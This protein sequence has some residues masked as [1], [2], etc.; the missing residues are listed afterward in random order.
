MK[1]V[2]RGE[3]GGTAPVPAHR[4]TVCRLLP[5]RRAVWRR[6]EAIP[7]DRR[8]LYSAA[9]EERIGCCRKTGKGLSYSGQCRALAE[10]RS[11][12]PGMAACPVA[13]QRG[14]LKR[15]DEAF[16][17][18]FRR[19]R[20]GGAPGFPRFR[21]R[22]S[23][24]SFRAV[25]GVRIRGGRIHLPGLGG[26]AV[27]RKGGNPYPDGRPV[28]AVLKRTGGKRFVTVC[29]TV[30]AEGP[31]DNGHAVGIDRNAGQV[32]GSDG[33]IHA[34]PDMARLE[35]KCRRLARRVSR[36]RKGSRRRERAK[37]QLAKARRKAANQRHNWHHQVSR[38][39]AERAGTVVLERLDVRG[40]TRSAKGTA[41]SPGRNL[42]QKASLNRAITG[43]GWTAFAAM[44]ECKAAN[45]IHVPAA[46]TS[47][48]CHECGA[49]DAASRGSQAESVCVACGHA[50]SA[51]VNAAKNIPAS[52]TGASARRGAFA[53]ATPATREISAE[54]G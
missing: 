45:V 47:Q 33:V 27:R 7:E 19:V 3:G 24:D 16:R 20:A 2:R 14:A 35:A 50:A 39:I 29:Y 9:L 46:Y 32:A 1:T 25:S 28:S 18:F 6:P 48:T 22:R 42:K 34:M 37:R 13:I 53:S 31:A 54:A 43:T 10:C 26:M 23:F 11:D 8:Q 40:M 15:P 36:R 41:E 12:I 5:Q 17:R 49:A 30:Q 52:G 51:D 4:Q 38:R 21:G 44:L